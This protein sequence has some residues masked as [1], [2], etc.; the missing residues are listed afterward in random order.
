MAFYE[1]DGE[2]FRASELTRGPWDPRSQHAGPPAALLGRALERCEPRAG[3][4]IGRVTLEILGPVPLGPLTVRAGVVRPGRSVELLEGSLH[5][6]DGELMRAR[7]WR[8]R[9]GEVTLDGADPA[10]PG[11]EDGR[12]A[13]F[14]PTGQDTGYHTAME[15]RFVRGSFL[16][17]GPATVWMRMRVPLVAGERPSA[18]ERVLVAADSGNGVSAALDW[19]RFI[20]VNTDLTVQLLREPAGEWVGLDAVTHV[21][22]IGMTDTA[23]FDPDGRIGRATQTLLV[24]ER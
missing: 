14:F 3:A 6:P 5:A 2:R 21:D 7:A 18:L 20:F 10:P 23:L 12:E 24:R 4:R 15:Y 16:D 19:R 8:V 1:A 9:A 17:P 13:D 11:P 22:G